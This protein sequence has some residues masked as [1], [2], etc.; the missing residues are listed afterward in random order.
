MFAVPF[1]DIAGIIGKTPAATR[2]L[3]SRARRRVRAGA[4]IP[5]QDL[6]SQ[7]VVVNAFLDAAH[8]GDFAGLVAVLDPDVVL[9]ADS[10]AFRE[11]RGAET[12]ARNA[13]MFHRLQAPGLDIHP[14]LVN[15][16]PGVVTLR[17]GH[18][19]SVVGFTV[20]ADRIAQLD[21]L[22]DPNR[23]SQLD[24]TVLAD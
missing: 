6:T 17:N 5:D 1:D 20:V 23:L 14:A 4:A 16:S 9:H 3:A 10:G 7:R 24:L 12:V 11:I 15:G 19:I 22:T 18:P 13:S 2:Q 21:I 8:N